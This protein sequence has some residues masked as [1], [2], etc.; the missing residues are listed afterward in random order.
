MN[1]TYLNRQKQNVHDNFLTRLKNIKQNHYKGEGSC[2]VTRLKTL[3]LI[4]SSENFAYNIR[5]QR[6]CV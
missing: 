6:V 3:L 5:T 2:K 4:T 1:K